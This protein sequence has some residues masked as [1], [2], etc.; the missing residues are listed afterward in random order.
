MAFLGTFISGQVLSAAELNQLNAVTF[1]N[2]TTTALSIVTATNTT[3]TFGALDI[4]T[5]A[6]GW[7]NTGT[8]RYTPSLSGGGVFTA[9][10]NITMSANAG[11]IS[12]VAILKNGATLVSKST[13]NLA[14][15]GANS[16]LCCTGTVSLNGSTD[17][18]TAIVYQTSGG[19]ITGNTRQFSAQLVRKT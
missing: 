19:T 12:Y 13:S 9:T 18:L 6:A 8:S 15:A 10:A 1:C 17:Y 3:F 16:S 4:V 11:A 14:T 5:D 7:F 2:T